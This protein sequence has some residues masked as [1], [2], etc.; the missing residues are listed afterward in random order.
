MPTGANEAHPT[1]SAATTSGGSGGGALAATVDPNPSIPQT[2]DPFIPLPSEFGCCAGEHC[3]SQSKV[4]LVYSKVTV[5]GA[6]THFCNNCGGLYHCLLL[7]GQYVREAK[8]ILAD[9]PIKFDPIKF[10]PYLLSP[11]GQHFYFTM[12]KGEKMEMCHLC[13]ER[14]KEVMVVPEYVGSSSREKKRDDKDA[15]PLQQLVLDVKTFI[16]KKEE[17]AEPNKFTVVTKLQYLVAFGTCLSEEERQVARLEDFV[18]KKWIKKTDCKPS[19]PMYLE[20]TNLRIEFINTREKDK[21]KND[22]TFKKEPRPNN[23]PVNNN[24]ENCHS[25]FLQ[26]HLIEPEDKA[27]VIQQLTHILDGIEK[28]ALGEKEKKQL[29]GRHVNASSRSYMRLIMAMCED[30]LRDKMLAMYQS[31]SRSELDGRNSEDAALTYFEEV[32][33]LYND[34]E[35]VAVTPVMKGAHVELNKSMTLP[36]E[37]SPID[38]E[39]VKIRVRDLRSRIN[40][41]IGNWRASGNGKGNFNDSRG[42]GT[43]IVR[44]N[45]IAYGDGLV[46]HG[47]DEDKEAMFVDDDRFQFCENRLSLLFFWGMLDLCGLVTFIQQHCKKCG[48]SSDK[49]AT[50]SARASGISKTTKAKGNA[51]LV[52][53]LMSHQADIMGDLQHQQKIEAAES[54]LLLLNDQIRLARQEVSQ[55]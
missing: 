41:A 51:Q 27:Y 30:R 12:E 44:F 17:D 26:R 25:S 36:F 39:T 45:E 29:S 50:S 20:A 52:K 34:E 1:A 40:Q 11:R 54:H 37:D 10:D 55:W 49:D 43:K 13:I 53:A 48:V 35:W 33:A 16:D 3:T 23:W 21:A 42:V 28:K 32:A 8:G 4:P 31:K 38:A 2:C 14:C 18:K 9:A 5:P 24:T 46:E 47:E 6:S 19:K 22:R 15:T 7:C